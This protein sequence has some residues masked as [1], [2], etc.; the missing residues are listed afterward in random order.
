MDLRGPKFLQERVNM[1]Y[2]ILLALTCFTFAV[3]PAFGQIG[4]IPVN[5]AIGQSLN[6]TLSKIR[7]LRSVTVVVT[8]ICTEYV[9]IDGFD[10]LTLKG[11]PGAA[12]QQPATTPSNGLGVWVLSIGASHSVTVDGLNIHSGPSALAG[13]GIGQNST[14]VRLRNL[15]VDGPASFTGIEIF[16]GSQVSLAG[17]TV[18]NAGFAGLAALDLSDVH[19]EQSLFEQTT[20]GGFHE[21]ID[22]G[23]GHVTVQSTTIR[24]MQTAIDIGTHGSVDIQSFNTY[25]PVV[26]PNDVVIENPAGSNFQGVHLSRGTLGLGDTKLRIT[27]AGQPFGGSSAAISASDDST[28]SDGNGNLI[29]T[30][31][32]GQGLFVSNNSHASLGGS[33][34]TGGQHGGLVVTNLS[35][36]SLLFGFQTLFGGNPTDV[37]CD[38]NSIVTGTARLAGVPITNCPNLLP[39][40]TVPLP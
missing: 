4:A 1:K 3:T 31:S 29:I 7:N 32:Q 12:L 16:E 17:V 5:C 15:T 34:I 24:D 30:G 8:G 13:I 33:T 9:T 35:S 14:D 20:S 2:K 40:D 19:I 6:Q 11:A 38:S 10:G 22:V 28:V 26:R 18:R 21:G 27:N 39:G 23:S 36:V 25:F 37:F